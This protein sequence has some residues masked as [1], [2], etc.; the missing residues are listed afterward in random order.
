MNSHPQVRAVRLNRRVFV[1]TGTKSKPPLANVRTGDHQGLDFAT[2]VLVHNPGSRLPPRAE[3]QG[4]N[5]KH[6]IA[7]EPFHSVVPVDTLSDLDREA[8]EKALR[9]LSVPNHINPGASV[10]I[11]GKSSETTQGHQEDLNLQ[12]LPRPNRQCRKVIHVGGVRHPELIMER[13]HD[14]VI[15]NAP[16][17]RAMGTAHAR[18][19]LDQPLVPESPL[20]SGACALMGV[21]AAKRVSDPAR[22]TPRLHDP[23][24]P[25]VSY[26]LEG[27]GLIRKK[28]RRL[29]PEPLL[30]Q[31][32][33]QAPAGTSSRPEEHIPQ[34]S[35]VQVSHLG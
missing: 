9:L 4:E 24:H 21:E 23:F 20:D 3:A 25:L 8:G 12:G 33:A 26:P 27:F 29:T 34:W 14:G 13:V 17:G 18:P 1:D 7:R 2:T 22:E 16:C 6:E 35:I 32:V 19:S 15:P 31:L 10:D 28:D 30:I 5:G 11:S